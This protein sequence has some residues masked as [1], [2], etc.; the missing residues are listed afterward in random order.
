MV[1]YCGGNFGGEVFEVSGEEAHLE[2]MDKF[3]EVSEDH[4]FFED[5]GEHGLVLIWLGVSGERN[6]IVGG[7]DD[8]L[9]FEEAFAVISGFELGHAGSSD[10][11]ELF[12]EV[13]IDLNFFV[14]LVSL[15]GVFFESEL[16]VFGLGQDGSRHGLFHGAV[17]VVEELLFLLFLLE[18]EFLV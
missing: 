1:V 12:L 5:V 9:L 6:R 15:G 7:W 17:A 2:F 8:G 3:L 10:G 16:E 4:E 14:F 11:L 18:S 13:F